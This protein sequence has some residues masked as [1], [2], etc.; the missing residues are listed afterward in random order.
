MTSPNKP[1]V[2]AVVGTDHH[3]FNRVVGWLDAWAAAH[4]AA[5]VVI[6]YGTST[7]PVTAEGHD[8]LPVQALEELLR[9]ADAVVCHGG[10]GTIMEAREAGHLPIVV[11]RDPALGE[12]VD[13]HQQRFAARVAELGQVFLADT[14][15]ELS[16][17]LE[18]ALAGD[19]ALRVSAGGDPAASATAAFGAM[20]QTLVTGE[21]QA[22]AD[23]PLRILY[24]AGWGRSGSTLLDRMLGQVTGVF[25]CGELRDIWRRGVIENRLCGCGE[26]FR[27]CAVWSRV[28]EEAFGGW[29]SL[30][31][32]EAQRLRD[33]LDRPWSPPVVMSS[34][35]VPGADADVARYVE[36]LTTLYR[37]IQQVTGAAVIVDSSKIPTYALLL[38][39]IPQ[40]D[41]RILHLVRDPRGVVFSWQK[42][43]VRADGDGTDQMLRYGAASAS[44]RYVFYNVMAHGM[45]LLRHTPYQ[46]LR[47]EDLI[48]DPEPVLR[49]VL[50]HAEVTAPATLA[51]L[52]G[53][54]ATLNPNH[55][56][57]GNPM[58]LKTGPLTLRVDDG[59][60]GQMESRQ[61]MTVTALTA[62][63]A[64]LYRYGYR[65]GRS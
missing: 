9:A 8:L 41:L 27:D 31:V 53:H 42:Q 45:R 51:F 28:G 34:K 46:F 15:E 50:A 11:A 40:V 14:P 2:V 18:R 32:A 24:I 1:L 64:F 16:G 25:S 56:V 4:P 20:V 6:Q 59:W 44:A 13:A 52:K 38:R 37:A 48:A 35:A 30:D 60:R 19:A 49:R 3:P 10:P 17:L 29:D 57:D 7:P 54:E 62:P 26:P 47:Y 63:L 43:V 65:R 33:K 12:H 39:Q 36:L 55:T 5:R 58:R 22:G 23:Q 21:A 61:R